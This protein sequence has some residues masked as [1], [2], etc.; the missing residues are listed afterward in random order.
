MQGFSDGYWHATL[1]EEL[2]R[3]VAAIVLAHP[4]QSRICLLLSNL[5]VNCKLNNYF[6]IHSIQYTTRCGTRRFFP[7][8][9]FYDFNAEQFLFVHAVLW[10]ENE[11]LSKCLSNRCLMPASSEGS[12]INV[13]QHFGCPISGTRAGLQLVTGA[14]SKSPERNGPSGGRTDW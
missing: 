4:G 5:Q 13:T 3:D 12:I 14:S 10:G 11:F 2:G 8:P 7:D 6:A 1:V 9:A